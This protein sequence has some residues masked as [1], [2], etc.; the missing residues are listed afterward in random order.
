MCNQL[1]CLQTEAFNVHEVLYTHMSK[2]G[3]DIVSS[4]S[5]IHDGIVSDGELVIQL[6]RTKAKMEG[7][8]LKTSAL[9][10][11]PVGIGSSFEWF[12]VEEGVIIFV[13]GNKFKV[14]KNG[15]SK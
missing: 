9:L 6:V 13:D 5:N 4:A 12:L 7:N 1:R 11:C 14:L 3:Q 8:P 10:V 15:V 2:E